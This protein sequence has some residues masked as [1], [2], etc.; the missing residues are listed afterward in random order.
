MAARGYALYKVQRKPAGQYWDI[1]DTTACQVYGGARTWV[2]GTLTSSEVASTDTAVAATDGL[3]RQSG[4]QTINAEF[5]SSNGGWTADGG[6][7]YTLAREDP[8]DG[9]KAAA[10]TH[11]WAASITS[12]E[13]RPPSPP[14]AP[15]GR[16]R[17]PLATAAASGAAGCS[18]SCSAGS[19]P[20][21]RA[22]EQGGHRQPD[23]LCL[24]PAQQLV[25]LRRPRERDRRPV[26]VGPVACGRRWAPRVSEEQYGDGYSWREYQ[27][28]RLY[29]S[30]A[31]GV[32]FVRGDI[33]T[34]F[35]A[36][37]GPAVLGAPSTDEG[38]AGSGGAFN[39]FAKDASIYWTADTGAQVVRGAVRS[40]WLALNAEWGL[41]L[42]DRR[43]GG[44]AGCRRCGEAGVRQR[45]G[46]L[47]RHP[48]ARTSC[49]AA[50]PPAWTAAGGATRLGLPVLR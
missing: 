19:T 40:R 42:P 12:A 25:H 22:T 27:R 18:R 23:P 4:G 14:S 34:A 1:C 41:G 44:S 43:R 48:P 3:V 16:W 45:R 38:A 31:T 28:G 33:L 26:R 29:W 13:V 2:N 8:W 15:C 36:A 50:W 5:S 7:S 6:T 47:V 46:L 20:P 30:A 9:L 35:L 11:S 32:M 24:R 21:G 49:G 17:S 37:G 39:H 10:G